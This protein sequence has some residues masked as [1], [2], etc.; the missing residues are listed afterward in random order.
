MKPRC[1]IWSAP[2]GGKSPELS[3]GKSKMYRHCE[4]W[5]YSCRLVLYFF[6][7]SSSPVQKQLTHYDGWLQRFHSTISGM[8]EHFSSNP[9][10][11]EEIQL[12]DSYKLYSKRYERSVFRAQGCLETG[13]LNHL[14]THL[15]FAVTLILGIRHTFV[16]QKNITY[17]STAKNFLCISHLVRKLG[18]EQTISH[19]MAPLEK[20]RL[21]YIKL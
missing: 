14:F 15:K 7:L 13:I 3:Y 19:D 2:Q 12:C 17:Y 9:L 11:R 6:P 20:I 16:Q 10:F 1:L 4:T 8:P 21:I 5:V 18:S